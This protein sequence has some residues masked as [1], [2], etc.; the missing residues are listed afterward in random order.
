MALLN[1]GCSVFPTLISLEASQKRLLKRGIWSQGP[2]AL[3]KVSIDSLQGSCEFPE[4]MY[5]I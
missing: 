3:G 2:E 1:S 5:K 4:R